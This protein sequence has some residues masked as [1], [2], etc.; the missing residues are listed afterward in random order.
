M[1][2]KI[3]LTRVPIPMKP[4]W[5]QIWKHRS[6]KKELKQVQLFNLLLEYAEKF[7]I[8]Y[9][10]RMCKIWEPFRKLE[11]KS[12]PGK[13]LKIKIE[14]GWPHIIVGIIGLFIAFCLF[15]AWGLGL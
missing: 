7:E 12:L 9:L 3:K 1:E 10:K 8:P 11:D 5:W 6:Y 2:N 13:I 14:I 15:V 4:K